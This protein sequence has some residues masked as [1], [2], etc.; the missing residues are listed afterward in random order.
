MNPSVSKLLFYVLLMLL[1]SFRQ[2]FS[3]PN[4]NFQ[5]EKNGIKV[6]TR[7]SKASKFDE[8]KA[9][10]DIKTSPSKFISV[11]SD[12][13]KYPFWVYGTKKTKLIERL[14]NEEIIYHSEISAPFPFSNRDFYSRLK[15]HEEADSKTI[16]ITA[17]GLPNY[18]PAEDGIVRVPFLH[19][20]WEVT[21]VDP[22]TLHI[23]YTTNIDAGGNIPAWLVNLFSTNGPIESFAKLKERC[24]LEK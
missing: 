16:T 18:K 3:Q 22:L 7:P 23:V 2:A 14:N 5:K 15:I 11:I 1:G 20:C 21:S 13:E 24:K 10:L 6:S 8:I 9:E 12:V 19:S 17:T 4:W